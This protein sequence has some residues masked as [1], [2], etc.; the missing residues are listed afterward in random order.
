MEPHGRYKILR[1]SKYQIVSISMIRFDSTGLGAFLNIQL[2]LSMFLLVLYAL[3]FP[4][5]VMAGGDSVL[6]KITFYSESNGIYRFGFEEKAGNHHLVSG[7]NRLEVHLIYKRV[8]WY[9]W[10]PLIHTTHPSRDSTEAALKF[11]H[12]SFISQK[13][14]NFGYIGNGLVSSDSK[15]VF[16]SKGLELDITGVYSFHDPV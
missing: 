6:G 8:P 9:S 14:I 11:I 1:N 5:N 13:D 12:D 3:M 4:T 7:C 10:L 2:N 16:D 15:C